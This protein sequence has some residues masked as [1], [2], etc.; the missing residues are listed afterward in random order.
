MV[1]T[2]DVPNL[3]GYVCVWYNIGVPNVIARLTSIYDVDEEPKNIVFKAFLMVVWD[4]ILEGWSPTF[5]LL[6]ESK[7]EGLCSLWGRASRHF[8]YRRV[9]AASTVLHK[10]PELGSQWKA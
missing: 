5:F 1:S 6:D 7:G 4:C 3:H 2:V 9:Q 10:G 8:W